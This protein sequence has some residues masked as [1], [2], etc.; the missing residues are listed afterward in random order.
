ME[1]K[2][3]SCIYYRPCLEYNFLFWNQLSIKNVRNGRILE[4]I[5]LVAIKNLPLVTLKFSK[6]SVFNIKWVNCTRNSVS[7]FSIENCTI[8]PI[9]RKFR[10]WPSPPRLHILFFIFY[11]NPLKILHTGAPFLHLIFPIFAPAQSVPVSLARIV[12]MVPFS[13]SLTFPSLSQAYSISLNFFLRCA[14]EWSIDDRFAARRII[15]LFDKWITSTLF[16]DASL[17]SSHIVLQ[18][19]CTEFFDF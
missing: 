18:A 6:F 5:F 17:R 8:V 11:H 16:A 1:E 13:L 12:Q 7:D 15:F 3:F 10:F 14:T 19:I 4:Y 9:H 2:Y